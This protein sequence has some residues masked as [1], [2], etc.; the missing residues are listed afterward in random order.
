M[1]PEDYF[2]LMDC[3]SEEDITQ[4]MQTRRSRQLPTG[5]EETMEHSVYHENSDYPEKKEIRMTRRGLA[6]GTAV[7]AV[8]LALNVGF[9][10]FLLH[11]SV[12]TSNKDDDVAE[13]TQTTAATTVAADVTEITA[14]ATTTQKASAKTTAAAKTT[15]K[16]AET[17]TKAVSSQ[18]TAAQTTVTEQLTTA[19]ATTKTAQQTTATTTQAEKQRSKKL[20]YSLVPADRSYETNG[21]NEN[22]PVV[23]H[24][25]AGEPIKMKLTVQNDPGVSSFRADFYMSKFNLLSETGL[26]YYDG[27]VEYSVRAE[28]LNDDRRALYIR[29]EG[30]GSTKAPDGAALAEYTLLA[31]AKPGRYVIEKYDTTEGGYVS[32]DA[33]D[34]T[35]ILVPMYNVYLNDQTPVEDYDL[36]GAEIIVDET[37]TGSPDRVDPDTLEGATVYMEPVTAHAG[38]KH[39]PVN[40]YVKDFDPFVSGTIMLGYDPALKP[41]LYDYEMPGFGE[42]SG[43]GISLEGTLLENAPLFKS[44]AMYGSR[45]YIC[46]NNYN[47]M[48]SDDE[49][50]LIEIRNGSSVSDAEI[51]ENGLL[52]TMY[53]D[54][55]EECGTYQI[56]A[57][58]GSVAGAD[59]T[60]ENWDY[61]EFRNYIPCDI[62]V[63]P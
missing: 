50:N 61:Q 17:K 19:A 46:F 35:E 26:N 5:E 32:A 39:V 20:T 55:P 1:K 28:E 14:A 29:G 33:P 51:T 24:A 34:G 16:F 43:L 31:P 15:K 45:I 25:K 47:N 49:D 62:T 44:G 53:F 27:T 59:V 37:E 63:I 56:A 42:E 3:V 10:S 11:D 52:F 38:Q 60:P 41:L 23:F 8:L 18:T 48:V 58:D 30:N 57:W 4:M 2:K 7:A 54:M 21:T 6:S 36:L 12:G 22:A 13:A 40:V 9:G